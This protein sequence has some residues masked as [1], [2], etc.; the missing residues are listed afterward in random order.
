[1]EA[2]KGVDRNPRI[3][4]RASAGATTLTV[5]AAGEALDIAL[6]GASASL[7]TAGA[8]IALDWQLLLGGDARFTGEALLQQGSGALSGTM[9]LRALDLAPFAKQAPGVV[10]AAG[11]LGGDVRLGG[12]LRE[13]R[14]AGVLSLRDG[15]LGHEKLPHPI[16]DV[17]LDVEFSGAEARLA[18]RFGSV[19]GAGTL[20]GTARFAGAGAGWSADLG[21]E[22]RR[23]AARAHARQHA[24]GGAGPARAARPAST[25]ASAG[26]CTSRKPT[27]ASTACPPAPSACR[28]TP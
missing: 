15:M 17:V 2:D 5:L 4:A 9:A 11:T 6:G 14:A 18:G 19:A 27:S 13:P 22:I 20:D 26:N 28:P 10:A 23:P 21:L 25:P 3:E 16:E 24:H 8:G 1:V 7:R 12:S